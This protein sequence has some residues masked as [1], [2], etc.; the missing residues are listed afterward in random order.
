MMD[1]TTPL[2]PVR[3]GRY[4]FGIQSLGSG[5]RETREMVSFNEVREMAMALPEVEEGTSY[6]T[7]AFLVRKK[8]F[9]RLHEDGDSLVL[10]I[11]VFERQLLLDAEPDAFYI[12][13]HYRDY[14]AV[15]ARLS[16]VDRET[17]R[18]RLTDSWRIRAPKKLAAAFERDHPA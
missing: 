10:M 16:A 15:L 6:G 8:R 11:N 17:L 1:E 13:D 14:P 3:G 7:P 12:T 4:A 2:A 18:E 5:G 9:C